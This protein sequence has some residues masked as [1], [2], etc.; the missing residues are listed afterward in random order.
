[1]M[2]MGRGKAAES[3]AADSEALGRAEALLLVAAAADDSAG[4]DTL[5]VAPAENEAV[6]Y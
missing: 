5:D 6:P 3:G 1:M 4:I 2:L